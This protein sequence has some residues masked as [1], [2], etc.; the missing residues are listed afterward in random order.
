[1][2]KN[3]SF[4]NMDKHY[5]AGSRFVAPIWFLSISVILAN[6]CILSESFAPLAAGSMLLQ[7]RGS[8]LGG[9]NQPFL[10][11]DAKAFKISNR[12]IMSASGDTKDDDPSS[13]EAATSSEGSRP[14]FL[15]LEPREDFDGDSDQLENG[16]LFIGPLI[17]MGSIFL[18]LLPF[19]TD[20]SQTFGIK[21]ISGPH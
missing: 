13:I 8:Y 20:E 4:F 9:T 14:T 15:G 5:F 6:L 18:I 7:K 1:M 21:V 3:I 19:I 11:A 16:L 2:K 10:A 17:L 12:L